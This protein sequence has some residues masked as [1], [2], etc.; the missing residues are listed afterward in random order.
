MVSH[1]LTAGGEGEKECVDL[2]KEEQEKARRREGE[3]SVVWRGEEER[4][5]WVGQ[6]GKENK[7]VIEEKQ[8][9]GIADF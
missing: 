2:G 6:A 3:S 7:W 4:E 1:S 9:P 5:D 8:E